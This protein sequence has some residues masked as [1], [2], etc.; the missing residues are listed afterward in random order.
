MRVKVPA[1]TMTTTLAV[2]TAS[3]PRV[4]WPSC[5]AAAAPMKAAA[6]IVVTEIATP[7]VEDPGHRDDAGAG[8]EQEIAGNRSG[9]LP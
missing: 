9:V 3:A 2:R 4:P 6:G 1:K 7:T 5:I 8:H